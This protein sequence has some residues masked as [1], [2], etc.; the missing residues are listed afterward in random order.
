MVAGLTVA[1]R[2]RP[3]LANVLLY[4]NCALCL[5]GYYAALPYGIAQGT[6]ELPCAPPATAVHANARLCCTKPRTAPLLCAAALLGLPLVIP[7]LHDSITE[8][9]PDLTLSKSQTRD[10]HSSLVRLLCRYI[11]A[12]TVIYTLIVRSQPIDCAADSS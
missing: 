4:D 6:V 11:L 10:H 9:N 12:Q 5:V 1:V 3:S 8:P 2:K 7:H